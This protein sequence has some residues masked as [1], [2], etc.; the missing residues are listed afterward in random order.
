M[1]TRQI[2]ASLTTIPAEQFGEAGR[3]GRIANGQ[4]ADLVVLDKDPSLDVRRFASVRFTIRNGKLIYKANT[5]PLIR[6]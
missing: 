6:R 4:A 5:A 3:S 1:D 2:L